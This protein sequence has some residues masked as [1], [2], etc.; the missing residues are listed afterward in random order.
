M[1]VEYLFLVCGANRVQ[2]KGEKCSGEGTSI[3]E[4]GVK[5]DAMRGYTL[6]R[7]APSIEG[8]W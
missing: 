3:E 7:H 2:T 5:G 1:G 6:G 8:F 4:N